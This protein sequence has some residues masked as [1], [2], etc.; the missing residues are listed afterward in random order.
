[1]DFYYQCAQC[2]LRKQSCIYTAPTRK[3][4]RKPKDDNSLSDSR[5]KKLK[6]GSQNKQD[7]SSSNLDIQLT[8]NQKSLLKKIK[9][10]EYDSI[11][12]EEIVDLVKIQNSY[13]E[14]VKSHIKKTKREK[15]ISGIVNS[16]LLS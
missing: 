13:I 3:R 9:N 10:G 16:L 11:S 2:V 5:I 1:M 6:S 7:S 4:G 14:N 12:K 15:E 8:R